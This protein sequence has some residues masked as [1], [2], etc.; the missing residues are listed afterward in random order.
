[1]FAFFGQFFDHGLDLV[2]KGGG[3]VIMPLKADDPLVAGPDHIFGNADD[4]PVDQRFM[5]M[6][7][8]TNLP[9]PTASRRQ[10]AT[11]QDESA[12]DIQEGI[13]TTTPW[14]DQNQTYTS[15]PSHQ[16]FLRQYAH[17]RAASPQQTGKVLD[18]GHCAPRGRP[19]SPGDDRSATS[20]TGPRSRQQA[21]TMLGIRLTDTDVFDVPLILTDPYGHFKP[22]A[23]RLPAARAARQR[24]P[25]G[26][27]GGQRRRWASPSR[28]TR[29]GPAMRS[30]TTSRTA[31]CRRAGRTST[32][33][34]VAG[35]SLADAAARRAPTTT[36]CSTLHFVTGDGRGNENIALTTV[37]Q[38]FH[39]EHNRLAHD[40]DR[41]IDAPV[42]ELLTPA[43]IAAWHAIDMPAPAGTTASG[44]SRRRGS[45]PRCSTS[46]SCSRSSRARSSR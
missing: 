24:A 39:A 21:A 14:V 27:P 25:R 9:G 28:P 18:G 36:S 42:A 1:M 8:A 43:E 17:G 38:L 45:S 33:N 22:G 15:H 32:P 6:T 44:C 2:T 7:R 31:P 11:P 30:S 26:Q 20:A 41:L 40:I 10:P 12:D 35:T 16:V 37:H 23:E 4:L 34:S 13:N 3:T 46:T 29:S 5:V 19:A